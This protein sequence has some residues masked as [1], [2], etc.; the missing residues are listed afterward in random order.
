MPLQLY[1]SAPILIDRGYDYQTKD[2]HNDTQMNI[3]HVLLL[4]I[5]PLFL[6]ACERD[7]IPDICENTPQFCADLHTDSWCRFERT[8]LIRARR[9]QIM[10]PSD[11][12]D[13]HL[14]QTLQQY[15]DCLEPLLAIEYTRNK[16]RKN[17]KVEAVIYAKD[18]ITQLAASTA[19]SDDPY[20][21]LWHWQHQR[22]QQAK[23]RFLQ[24]AERPEMQ[25]P[26]LQKALAELLL[27]RNSQ[28]AELALHQALSLYGKNADIDTDII[29]NLL[30]LYIREQR[31]Q[32]AWIWS[33]VLNRLGH[34]SQMS[35]DRMN[36]YAHFDASQQQSM[37]QDTDRILKQL[38]A[39]NYRRD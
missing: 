31:Y 20:L 14:I 39:G 19:Q 2:G 1:L 28:A 37:Q 29:A 17:D 30:T 16:E 9:Q 27:L 24:L 8:A 18:A 25:Q 23:A 32:E 5:A 12:N 10:V 4:L 6:A 21:L 13:Y 33:R 7:L 36:A 22:S 26:K 11:E 15:Q 3:K 34:S 38:K 35:L